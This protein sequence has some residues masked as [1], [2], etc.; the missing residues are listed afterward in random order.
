MFGWIKKHENLATGAI[1]SRQF[2]HGN[3]VINPLTYETIGFSWLA[4]ISS[5]KLRLFPNIFNNLL[6]LYAKI[7][8]LYYLLNLFVP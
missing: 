2:G 8:K 6:C 3:E 1:E 7:A 5:H 4:K